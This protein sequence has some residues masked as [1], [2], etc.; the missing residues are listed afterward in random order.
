MLYAQHSAPKWAAT[1]VWQRTALCIIMCNCDFYLCVKWVMAKKH[2]LFFLNAKI[3]R[4]YEAHIIVSGLRARKQT[5]NR[6]HA[7]EFSV[8][9][10][11]S[12]KI[13]L[14]NKYFWLIRL[15][16]SCNSFIWFAY[17]PSKM[18]EIKAENMRLLMLKLGIYR[19]V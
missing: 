12:M 15:F 7:K 6:I 16:G 11:T 13:I 9:S 4:R 18:T 1:H 19:A 17:Q 14:K 3:F 8:K 2:S 10:S 5:M